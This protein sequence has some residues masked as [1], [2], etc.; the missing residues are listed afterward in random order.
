MST[1]FTMPGKIGDA[2]MQWPVP[3]W[4][5][6]ERNE[7]ITLWLD[8][9]TLKPLVPLFEAQSCVEKVE[10]KGGI[11]NYQCG[12]QP[13]HFGL[14]TKDLQGLLVYHLGFR[15]FPQRQISLET[16]ASSRV[17][18]AVKPAE[19]ATT[20]TIEAQ[21]A[22]KTGKKLILHGQSVCPHT[23]ATPGFW[24]FIAPIR[25]ELEGIFSE[26]VWVGSARDL[27][28]AETTYGKV[29]PKATYFD[30]GGDFQLLANQMANADLVI[31]A[32]SCVA[33]L[34]GQL[35][36]PTIRVHDPIAGKSKTI[37]AGLG[38]NQ[39][40][41]LEVALRAQWP[42]FRDRW[43]TCEASANS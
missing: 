20:P 14:E 38:A 7:K 5:A 30:D 11:E 17:P 43:V 42:E 8:E 4:Y 2:I 1:V 22:A 23:L 36:V 37:W 24:K 41:D 6:K 16:R 13:W 12:G 25:A 33:A 10:L 19:F 3:F 26:I 27:E 9:G 39:S 31:G 34:G 32:G 28:V 29:W 35:K 15:G 18:I 40:T 21:P